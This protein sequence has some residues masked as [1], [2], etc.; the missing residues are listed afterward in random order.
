MVLVVAGAGH[1]DESGQEEGEE[2]G[3]E[4][5]GP[6]PPAWNEA[7][8]LPCQVA[9]REGKTSEGDW[10]RTEQYQFT[11]APGFAARPLPSAAAVEGLRQLS[12]CACEPR[13]VPAGILEAATWH[14]S[15]LLGL[16]TPLDYI[17]HPI[18]L[19]RET[20]VP[21]RMQPKLRGAGKQIQAAL[22][23]GPAPQSSLPR[24]AAGS[25]WADSQEEWPLGKLLRP[26]VTL[27][28]SPV[29]TSSALARPSGKQRWK[30]SGRGLGQGSGAQSPPAWALPAPTGQQGA[31]GAARAN[32]I[33]PLGLG[34]REPI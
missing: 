9:G 10:K 13:E 7:V 29:H 19:Q 34:L 18:A 4:A 21:L 22:R 11:I 1:G 5:Q 20:R 16:Q 31:Q 30:K 25:S 24:A 3:T 15:L 26:S 6:A 17:S 12:A 2:E 32:A 33:L 27:R 8:Q 14:T 23:P 28:A